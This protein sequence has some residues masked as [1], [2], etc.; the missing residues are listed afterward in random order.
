MEKLFSNSVISNHEIIYKNDKPY[1]ILDLNE[2]RK[3]IHP[4][5]SAL[6]VK[7]KKKLSQEKS[8]KKNKYPTGKDF[9]KG[10]E[11]IWKDR[12]DITDS[13][14]FVNNLRKKNSIRAHIKEQMFQA[15]ISKK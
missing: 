3:L 15:G 1:I 14:E 5:D 8:R 4:I 10:L 6:E 13:V 12:T 7:Q 11:G 2:Y 9:M